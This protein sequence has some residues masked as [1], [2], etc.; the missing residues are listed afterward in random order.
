[1]RRLIFP[2]LLIVAGCTGTRPPG[3]N[4]PETATLAYWQERPAVARVQSPD[5]KVLWEAAEGSLDRFGFETA[6][7]D[8]R[9]GRLTSEPMISAQFFEPFRDEVRTAWD[10]LESSL[11]TVRRRVVFDFGREGDAYWVEPRVIIEKLALGERRVT[12]AIDYNRV[13]GTGHQ[14]GFSAS[15]TSGQRA[16]GYWYAVGRDENL[17]QSLLNRLAE[18]T[19]GTRIAAR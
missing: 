11:S 14:G 1:M 13:L 15:D 19:A 6:L 10:R 2:L 3:H 12:N 8:Y 16:S 18:Q 4:D 5:Y 9:G 17:E 7:S